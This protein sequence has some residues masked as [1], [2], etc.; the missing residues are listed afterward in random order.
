MTQERSKVLQETEANPFGDEEEEEA[1]RAA[2]QRAQAAASPS[3]AG[4]STPAPMTTTQMR[5]HSKSSSLSGSFFGSSS[6]SDKK[7]DKD[8]AKGKRK[9]FNLEAEK[10]Q[11][12]TVIADSSIATTNLMNALQSINREKE[13]ISENPQAVQ[14]FEECKQLRRRVLRYVRPPCTPLRYVEPLGLTCIRFTT[15]KMSSG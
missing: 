2:Q 7:K 13:R 1:A 11:M 10:G 4:P 15:S 12:K 5:G 14:R 6:S 9:P 3:A 8:K